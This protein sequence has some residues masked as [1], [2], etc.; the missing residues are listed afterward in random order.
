MA[1]DV[2]E[3]I[4]D[5]KPTFTEDILAEEFPKDFKMQSLKHYDGEGNPV[6]HYI[7]F[8]TWMTI[9]RASLTMVVVPYST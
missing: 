6:N 4:N 9:R 1:G 8:Q 2:Q 7:T 3:V 5:S